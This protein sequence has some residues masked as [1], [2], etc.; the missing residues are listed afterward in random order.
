M[1]RVGVLYES[2]EQDSVLFATEEA[3]LAFCAALMDQQKDAV[4]WLDIEPNFNPGW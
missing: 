3:A 4:A 1:P 2:G